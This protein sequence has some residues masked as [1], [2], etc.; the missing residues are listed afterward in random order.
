[1]GRNDLFLD[2]GIIYG[3]ID[4]SDKI[5]YKPCKNHFKKFPRDRHNYYSVKRIIDKEIYTVGKKRR[6]S[7]FIKSD[8]I[9]RQIV[10]TAKA[11]RESIIG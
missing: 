11:G 7:R 3:S 5:W 4:L 6:E 10:L 1:M 2:S 9:L 8:R